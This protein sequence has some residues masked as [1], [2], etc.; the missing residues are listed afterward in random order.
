MKRKLVYLSLALTALVAISVAIAQPPAPR[1][2]PGRP[3]VD[4]ARQRQSTMAARQLEQVR[5]Q[6]GTM[7]AEHDALIAELKAIHATAQ[8]EEA[9]ATSDK[10][11]K[12]I[13]AQQKA[14]ETK[15]ARLENRQKALARRVRE[16]KERL[17]HP[18]RKAPDFELEGFDG[19]NASLE[20][21]RGRVVVLEWFSPD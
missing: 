19:R 5:H 4:P 8:E 15:V 9:K 21:Y 1:L 7:K 18:G 10:I 2:R 12:F 3:M 11:E 16:F 6:I 17:Q 20:K 14:Y 13:A